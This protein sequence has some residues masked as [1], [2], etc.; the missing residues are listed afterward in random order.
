MEE[1]DSMIR[2]EP[3]RNVSERVKGPVNE[4]LKVLQWNADGLATKSIEL[5]ERM[6]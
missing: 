6:R 5:G 3:Q 2:T 1:R 4:H